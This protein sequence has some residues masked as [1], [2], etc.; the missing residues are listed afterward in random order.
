MARAIGLLGGLSGG[1]RVLAVD[2]GYSN[3]TLC[4]VG[5]DRPLYSRRVH[6]CA[7]GKILESIMRVFNVSLDEA[8]HLLDAEGLT[9]A[10]S[11]APADA[12]TQAAIAD[13]ASDTL[14]ELIRQVKRTLQFMETQRRHLQPTEVWLLGGGASLRN[15]GPHVAQALQLPVHVWTMPDAAIPCAAGQRGALF[16]TAAA[17]SALAWRA[18]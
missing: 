14:G 12:Q 17:L 2:W 5:D 7:F 15:V 4:V 11:D 9:L 18:A 1:R 3:T 6:N 8:Q 16:S 13:A 10:D